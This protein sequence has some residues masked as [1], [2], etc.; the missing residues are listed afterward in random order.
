MGVP[1]AGALALRA[2]R[3]GRR[4]AGWGW[5]GAFGALLAG[6]YLTQSRGTI[7][8]T[9]VV[10]FVWVLASGPAARRQGR[11]AYRWWGWYR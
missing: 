11:N 1:L 6:V 7:I 10:L 2:L 9:V 4:R 5:L 8:A 3:S